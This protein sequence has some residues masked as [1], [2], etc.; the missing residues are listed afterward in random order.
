MSFQLDT[1]GTVTLES[2]AVYSWDGVPVGTK[3]LTPFA[4][5]YVEAMPW[6]SLRPANGWQMLYAGRP[7]GWMLA[8]TADE[9]L[10]QARANNPHHDPA[11]FSILTLGFLH[12]APATLE[13]IIGDCEVALAD[14]LCG[15]SN[16]P[17]TGEMFWK[18]RQ[19]NQ[20]N[21]MAPHFPPL[22]VTLGEDGLI[23]LGV[24]S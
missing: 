19:A 9:A 15:Y 5:G 21:G 2:G 17:Q 13:R 4:Q 23:Y 6:A 7:L 20:L 22:T 14:K 11:E 18:D 10:S 8:D 12:L 24:A 16:H 1:S 3:M